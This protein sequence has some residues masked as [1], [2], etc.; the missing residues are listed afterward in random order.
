MVVHSARFWLFL[1]PVGWGDAL[2]APGLRGGAQDAARCIGH[3]SVLHRSSEHATSATAP[4]CVNRRCGTG[5]KERDA[6]L[7]SG[8]ASLCMDCCGVWPCVCGLAVMVPA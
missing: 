7:M 4:Q 6:A 5:Q 3:R 2:L 1:Y 8:A